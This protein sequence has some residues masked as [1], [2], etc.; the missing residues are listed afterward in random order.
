MRKRITTVSLASGLGSMKKDPE[1]SSYP[2]V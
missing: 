2:G 1:P